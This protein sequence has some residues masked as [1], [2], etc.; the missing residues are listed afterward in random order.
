MT[1]VDKYDSEKTATVRKTE[2]DYVQGPETLELTACG[3]E[4]SRSLLWASLIEAADDAEDLDEIRLFHDRP[5]PLLAKLSFLSAAA[6]KQRNFLLLS[7]LEEAFSTLP[8][9]SSTQ[10]ICQREEILR[11]ALHFSI[12]LDC[13]DVACNVVQE[14]TEALPRYLVYRAGEKGMLKL[15]KCFVDYRTKVRSDKGVITALYKFKSIVNRKRA[16][17]TQHFELGGTYVRAED[18]LGWASL[19][20]GEAKVREALA[21]GLVMTTDSLA[22]FLLSEGLLPLFEE[23]LRCRRLTLSVRV[24]LHILATGHCDFLARHLSV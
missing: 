20:G 24:A 6:F 13:E 11:T 15:L 2:P 22:K 14:V 5:I 21:L 8:A 19:Y 7:R 16:V 17:R 12:A 3:M 1:A 10:V 23:L 18:V 4:K 9:D